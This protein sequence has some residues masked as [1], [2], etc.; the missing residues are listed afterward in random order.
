M[1]K[2]FRNYDSHNK[3]FSR[4]LRNNLTDA[5]NKLWQCIRNKQIEGVLF[6][7]QKPVGQYIVDFYSAGAKLVIEVDGSRHFEDENDQKDRL[8]DEY[9]KS[10]GL[11]VLRFDNSEVLTN[12]EGVID[13]ILDILGDDYSTG[14][15]K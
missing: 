14:I 11:K 6:N 4:S 8:R 2:R 13:K 15:D 12:I 9:L 7:R 5:E 3:K 10:L 1:P